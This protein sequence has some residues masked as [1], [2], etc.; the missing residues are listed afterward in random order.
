MKQKKRYKKS[1]AGESSK[2]FNKSKYRRLKEELKPDIFFYKC[3]VPIRTEELP[4]FAKQMQST[5]V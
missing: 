2:P 1:K 3:D 5:V 4:H